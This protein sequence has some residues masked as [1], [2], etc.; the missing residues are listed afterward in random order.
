MNSGVV[1][2]GC[3]CWFRFVTILMDSIEW[4]KFGP[5]PFLRLGFGKNSL[6]K[7]ELFKFN[8]WMPSICK[9]KM[10]KSVKEIIKK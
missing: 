3:W 5:S 7:T 8:L 4:D 6:K 1:F 9:M 10:V 2:N